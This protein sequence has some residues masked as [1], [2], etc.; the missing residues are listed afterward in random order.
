MEDIGVDTVDIGAEDMAGVTDI[1]AVI[2]MAIGMDII[3]VIGTDTMMDTMVILPNTTS[4]VT[5]II[6]IMGQ[7][8]MPSDLQI[9]P[10]KITT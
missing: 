1:G 6:H 2:I 10:L 3:M 9:R 7:E 5:I 4:T 8:K